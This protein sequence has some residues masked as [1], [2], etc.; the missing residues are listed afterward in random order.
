MIPKWTI[1]DRLVK[2]RTVANL[3][4]KELFERSGVSQKTIGRY[5]AGGKT[6]DVY[7]RALA[8]ACRVDFDWLKTGRGDGRDP[9]GGPADEEWCAPWESNPEP[10]DYG[11]GAH[12]KALFG[13][14]KVAEESQQAA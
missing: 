13:S 14:R 2:A 10:A 8:A 11:F 12:V 9:D 1:A 7:L 5:E 4:Q 3:T 6:N